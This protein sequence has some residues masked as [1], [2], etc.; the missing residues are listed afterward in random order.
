[1]DISP[2][3]TPHTPCA[4]RARCP[5]HGPPTSQP[6]GLPP[7]PPSTSSPP[8]LFCGHLHAFFPSTGCDF[9]DTDLRLAEN[10]FQ[11]VPLADRTALRTVDHLPLLLPVAAVANLRRGMARV[12]GGTRLF[13][14]QR[15]TDAWRASAARLPQLDA[16]R[17]GAGAVLQLRCALRLRLA[18]RT[19]LLRT[20]CLSTGTFHQTHLA[21]ARPPA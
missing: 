19:P 8:S 15:D 18:F 7:C 1:M 5:S 6:P 16:R 3:T 21:R 2:I 12:T 14:L 13:L 11:R 20:C 9:Y 4:A 10:A 17:L